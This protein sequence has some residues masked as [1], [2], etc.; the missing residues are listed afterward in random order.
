[1]LIDSCACLKSTASLLP[2]LLHPL[3]CSASCYLTEKHIAL[4]LLFLQTPPFLPRHLWEGTNKTCPD[5]VQGVSTIASFFGVDLDSLWRK[6]TRHL[7]GLSFDLGYIR[8]LATP[9]PPLVEAKRQPWLMVP[10]PVFK[11]WV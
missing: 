9:S 10:W 11:V 4:Y 6:G 8:H 5:Q 3:P 1:M 7:G 2:P